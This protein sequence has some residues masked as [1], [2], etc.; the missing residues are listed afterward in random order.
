MKIP[1]GE[2]N[3]KTVI[4][5]NYKYVD[6]TDHIARLEAAG[7]YLFLLRPRRFGKGLFISALEHYYDRNHAAD[8]DTLF[9]DLGMVQNPSILGNTGTRYFS[10][11]F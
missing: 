5:Q 1:Y 4:T 3:F 2:S 10:S 8:F 9:G 6:K 11:L 7:K